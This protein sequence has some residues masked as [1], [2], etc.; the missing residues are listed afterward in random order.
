MSS[1]TE[2]ERTNALSWRLIKDLIAEG[3]LTVPDTHAEVFADF[4]NKH[5]AAEPAPVSVPA[6]CGTATA[7][8]I[9]WEILGV[10]PKPPWP[11]NAGL[12]RANQR[13]AGDYRQADDVCGACLPG[14]GQV[15]GA[16]R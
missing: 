12:T 3:R 15:E 4:L 13:R 5:A 7:T 6:F 10:W 1:R 2:D 9:T 16:V 8:A 11:P 14:K